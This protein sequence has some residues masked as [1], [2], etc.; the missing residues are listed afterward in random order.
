MTVQEYYSK[1]RRMLGD[2]TLAVDFVLHNYE[3]RQHG[4]SR[5]KKLEI[6]LKVKKCN[7]ATKSPSSWQKHLALFQEIL[8]LP[9]TMRGDVVVCGWNNA[10]STISLSLA[11]GLTKRRLF[12]CDSFEG[13]PSPA[14]HEKNEISSHS[15]D[16]KYAQKQGEFG[17]EEALEAAMR[18]VERFGDISV[19]SLVKG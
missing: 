1:L 4:I 13:L 3:G 17:T 11:C 5:V 15:D 2:L 16:G 8:R 14:V 10:T 6:A 12:V 18:T 7:R 9:K 19:C